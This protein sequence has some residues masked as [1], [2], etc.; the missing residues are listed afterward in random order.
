MTL[1]QY[2]TLEISTTSNLNTCF[3]MTCT[4]LVT[5]NKESTFQIIV[6]FPL[7]LP[8]I[9]LDSASEMHIGPDE[10]QSQ[11]QDLLQPGIRLDH[12]LVWDQSTSILILRLKIRVCCDCVVVKAW[13]LWIGSELSEKMK[14][15]YP[16]GF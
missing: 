6:S 13:S 11:H 10:S 15:Q 12:Q 8:F 14:V 4:Y 2:S 9:L 5:V 7:V 3:S 1:I 16:Y